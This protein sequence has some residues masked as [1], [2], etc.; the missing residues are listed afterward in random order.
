MIVGEGLE[1][2]S[3]PA[4]PEIGVLYLEGD[5]LQFTCGGG[6]VEATVR[7]AV[8]GL[9]GL[10]KGRGKVRSAFG[11]GCHLFFR[12]LVLVD[13]ASAH[14]APALVPPVSS[15]GEGF[16]R[17]GE[18]FRG[19]AVGATGQGL[20]FVLHRYDLFLAGLV[21]PFILL[22][23]LAM[24]HYLFGRGRG[25]GHDRRLAVERGMKTGEKPQYPVRLFLLL[26]RSGVEAGTDIRKITMAVENGGQCG[27][28]GSVPKSLA[29][30]RVGLDF[31]LD[32]VDSGFGRLLGLQ[33]LAALHQERAH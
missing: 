27:D 30:G 19:Q 31:A 22:E 5:A 25:K 4:E 12:Y 14:Q 18:I 33:P 16:Q 3:Q 23:G 11:K 2:V 13:V 15:L 29:L 24:P 9:H 20:A 21:P 7:Q 6:L 28:I 32:V 26:L 1:G 10:L 8:G 17:D